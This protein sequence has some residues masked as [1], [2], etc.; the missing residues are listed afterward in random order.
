MYTGSHYLYLCVHFCRTK[1][2]L[3]TPI[4]ALSKQAS[5]T[6]GKERADT[7]LVTISIWCMPGRAKGSFQAVKVDCPPFTTSILNMEMEQRL[8][9]P[10]QTSPLP[11]SMLAVVRRCYPVWAFFLDFHI[12]WLLGC[13]GRDLLLGFF[14]CC[15]HELLDFHDNF[16]NPVL[17][18]M[19][20]K[21]VYCYILFE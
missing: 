10:P 18:C 15:T 17:G 12:S 21:F 6:F 16:S 3:S 9:H 2:L 14:Q 8:R 5:Y 11:I 7:I 13:V 1:L 20:R 19:R 4:V